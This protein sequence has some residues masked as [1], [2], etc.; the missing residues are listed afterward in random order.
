[1]WIYFI[2]QVWH[3][4][5]ERPWSRLGFETH[6]QQEYFWDIWHNR[7]Y[8]WQTVYPQPHMVEGVDYIEF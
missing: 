5:K 2:E 6:N 3:D 8:R 7:G 4:D 1:M